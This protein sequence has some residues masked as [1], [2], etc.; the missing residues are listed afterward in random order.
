MNMKQAVMN[1][2]ENELLL[3]SASKDIKMALIENGWVLLRNENYDVRS[4]SQLMT[5]LCQKLTYDPARE[6]ITQQS[7]KVD[8][9]TQAVGLHIENGTTPLPPDI[10]A[11]FSA[12]SASQG[13]QT[14]VCDGHLVWLNLPDK[15]KE[16]FSAPMTISRHL[17]KNIWQKY[18]A[19]A[20]NINTP[21]EVTWDDLQRFT[22]MIPGQSISRAENDGIEYHL[23]M[24]MIRD[25]NLKGI[26][27]FA[28]TLLGPSYN[29]QKPR[30]FFSDGVEIS[31]DLILELADLCEKYTAEIHWQD[32]DL[33]IIDNKRFMHGR[34]EILVP[35]ENRK[36]YISMGLG[37]NHNF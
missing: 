19:A 34:R 31:P 15:L 30:Y 5:S 22:D 24:N 29:Y 36:L 32:G 4:F 1:A 23:K 20:L 7:Q 9:G 11:F 25:D 8:A 18:V 33:A 35:L 26:P 28:N 14:T 37:M 2:G 17:P 16:K 27:A 21:E 3:K 13:S 12:L 6:N 10:I